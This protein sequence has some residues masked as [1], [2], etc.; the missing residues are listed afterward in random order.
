M[1]FYS[2]GCGGNKM[3]KNELSKT[4]LVPV[5]SV[6]LTLPLIS[7]LAFLKNRAIIFPIRPFAPIETDVFSLLIDSH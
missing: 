5:H 4:G 6:L 7:L 1:G 2:G 3:A